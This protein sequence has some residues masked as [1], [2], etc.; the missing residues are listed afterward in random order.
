MDE[1]ENLIGTDEQLS[2]ESLVDPVDTA[3]IVN[4]ASNKNLAAHLAVMDDSGEGI[5]TYRQIEAELSSEAQSLMA[6]NMVQSLREQEASLSAAGL[7]EFLVDPS[8]DD[9][10][11]SRI[12]REFLDK[13]SARFNVRNTLS[14]KVLAEPI[15]E[16]EE[17]AAVRLDVGAWVN[18]VNSY[19]KKEQ[20][21]INSEVAKNDIETATAFMDVVQYLS[22]YMESAM[23][24]KLVKDFRTKQETGED[25][26]GVAADAMVLL[27]SAKMEMVDALKKMPL[28]ERHKVKKA[29]A[30]MIRSNSSIIMADENDFAKTRFLNE[31]IGEEYD[32]VDK[33]I[34]NVTSVLDATAFGGS[35]VR[36]LR[37]AGNVGKGAKAS[38]EGARSVKG[39]YIP[40]DRV[41]P[42]MGGEAPRQGKTYQEKFNWTAEDAPKK[43]GTKVRETTTVEGEYYQV[44]EGNWE[45]VVPT[46]VKAPGTGLR[47]TNTY[48]GEAR[49][50]FEGNWE[51]YQRS[52]V[53]TP[54]TGMRATNVYD[55]EYET[56][57]EAMSLSANKLIRSNVQPVS[58]AENVKEVNPRKAAQIHAAAIMDET[59]EVAEAMYGTS[60]TEAVASDLAPQVGNTIDVVENK[61]GRIAETASKMID[62]SEDI[63]GFMDMR[64]FIWASD[65]EKAEARANAWNDFRNVKGATF[66]TNMASLKVDT[67]TGAIF[68][69]IYGPDN[70]GYRNAVEG[71]NHVL[72]ALRDLGVTPRD[73]TLLERTP[74]GYKPV[75][76]KNAPKLPEG[77]Y[78]VQ[79][80]YNW[81]M[82]PLD[83]TSPEQWTFKRNLFDSF[84]ASTALHG[85]MG[86]LSRNFFDPASMLDPRMMKSA[87]V[88]VDKASRL[89][90]ILL[91]KG[92]QFATALNQLPKERVEGVMDY[93]K[94]ANYKGLRFSPSDLRSR[95]F[96][97]E[98]IE[99]VRKWRNAW[100]ELYWLENDD[101]RQTLS[102]QGYR[103][104]IDPVNG[105]KLL[106]KPMKRAALKEIEPTDLIYLS[107]SQLNA[108]VSQATL[109][110]LY[111]QGE[112]VI[113]LRT[114]VHH[115]GD[116]IRYAISKEKPGSTYTRELNKADQVLPYREGYYKVAYK[117]AQFVVHRVKDKNGRV[118]YEQAVSTAGTRA[119]AIVEAERLARV[120]G[121]QFDKTGKLTQADYYV[122]GD[123]KGEQLTDYNFDVYTVSGRSSQ[124]Y[125]G[126][127][128]N[129]ANAPSY[130]GA[131]HSHIENPAQ[132]LVSASR[133]IARRVPMREWLDAMKAR[134]LVQYKDLI[135]KDKYGRPVFPTDIAEI[136]KKGR[137]TDKDVRD[138]RTAFAYISEMESGYI[139]QID[140]AY[141]AVL[142]MLGNKLGDMGKG[143]AEAGVRVIQES[144]G[145]V[146][147]SKNLAFHAYLVGHPLRQALI[148][149]HQA[150]LYLPINPKYFTQMPRDLIGLL[151]ATYGLADVRAAAK[152]A[153]RDAADFADMLNDLENSGLIASI[154]KQNLVRSSL[155]SLADELNKF[156]PY[157]AMGTLMTYSRKI[158]F[159]LGETI[160]MVVAFNVYRDKAL[161]E[162]RML[163]PAVLEE[164]GAAARNTSLGM[165][166]AGDMPYN[167]NAL[168]MLFQFIQ[169]PHKMATLLTT[170]RLLTRREKMTIAG[171][172]A[173]MWTLPAGTMY[174]LLDKM[175]LLP[176]NE[177]A[178]NLVV[179]GVEGYMFNSAIRAATGS[180]TRVDFS[181][182]SPFD[183][184]GLGE[185]VINMFSEGPLQVIANSP[186]GQLFYGNNPRITDAMRTAGQ[187]IMGDNTYAV[188]EKTYADV[189]K[190][191]AS[192]FSGVD[193][194]FKAAYIME[195]G[196]RLS[197]NGAQSGDLDSIAAVAQL[198]GFQTMEDVQRAYLKQ[199]AFKVND[200][201]RK[202][203][204]AYYDQLKRFAADDG[205]PFADQAFIRKV[206]GSGYDYIYKE[207]GVSGQMELADLLEKDLKNNDNALIM[208]ILK[209]SGLKDN[210]NIKR[211]LEMIKSWD[212]EK[213]KRLFEQLDNLDKTVEEEK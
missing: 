126:Q 87:Y 123:V 136:T 45:E 160:N 38:A 124:R 74:K 182:L 159:D 27:G 65:V 114:P 198:F 115:N 47:A 88:A 31:F 164:I 106:G 84:A 108:P 21:L 91:D 37:A 158:G 13:E 116:I 128:L 190:A 98:E 181:S 50:V 209:R 199:K 138:A 162:G 100:D 54:G 176:E 183:P 134:Y 66:R 171:Y 168:G 197:Y 193:A 71:V 143:K 67:D 40:R 120:N 206:L 147:F 121:L 80:K 195:H 72:Y 76:L 163:T 151:S 169:A 64:G 41:D 104:L 173:A 42:T 39:E 5:S 177:E 55:G 70:G 191:A 203:V 52:D 48:E 32:N 57:E 43:P 83:I 86:T 34:D 96:T 90:Q 15:E 102:K 53:K 149:A 155:S 109:Q 14:Q 130:N 150:I 4:K 152:M 156:G 12:A 18:E 178:R 85:S 101:M 133:N 11:K 118:L 17:Q 77:D 122:R 186:S 192:I 44:F 175:D 1:L 148:Q 144:R 207:Y 165:N 62:P 36:V 205:I 137:G 139:N 7:S 16:N 200:R 135:G 180:N 153:G 179:E 93:L 61:P 142:N 172:T 23:V 95:G 210:A 2:L 63:K 59:G 213:Q 10:T 60:R 97:D 26:T 141:R 112:I 46:D 167:Q 196:K 73:L 201:L 170:N 49:Q 125:R 94:E 194:G 92:E 174:A 82:K 184:Y 78:L 35:V 204:K 113:K 6:D 202:D 58:V 75:S 24:G 8:Y 30:D 81:E 189:L 68:N 187:W 103:M 127:R 157:R 146:E 140:D 107:S 185:S 22:P 111:D 89:E 29:L 56:V 188:D 132:A 131:N 33:W 154:D 28:D 105:D 208:R 51:S 119:D 79:V 20:A 166:R 117:N 211:D 9:A 212:K 19:K 99:V 25:A 129:E 145:P 161:R 3:P 69:G 110:A